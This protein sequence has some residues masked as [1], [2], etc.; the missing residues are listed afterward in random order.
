M[1][2][3]AAATRPHVGQSRDR[4]YSLRERTGWTLVDFGL[5][6]VA[7]PHRPVTPRPR[8]AGY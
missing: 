3:C 2:D 5:K 7:Q 8:P 1:R 6:L 4:Q